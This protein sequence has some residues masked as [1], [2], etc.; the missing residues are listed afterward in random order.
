MYH[1]LGLLKNKIAREGIPAGGEFT[2]STGGNRLT[3]SVGT[4]E[5]KSSRKKTAKISFQCML[6]I[7]KSLELSYRKMKTLC[8]KLRQHLGRDSVESRISDKL[9][10]VQQTVEDCY[11]TKSETFRCT[12]DDEVVSDMVFVENCSDFILH[13]ITEHAL[14]PSTAIVQIGVDSGHWFLKYIANVFDPNEKLS[15]DPSHDDAEVKRSIILSMVEDIPESN[16]NL[17]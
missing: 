8:T 4:P 12:G 16:F 13:T 11:L 10:A 3:V 2:L 5:N 6:E 9:Q 1:I 17:R 14:D 7:T 15:T